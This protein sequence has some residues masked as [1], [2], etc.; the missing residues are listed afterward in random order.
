MRCLVRRWRSPFRPRL[1]CLHQSED[2]EGGDHGEP[3]DGNCDA[4]RRAARN[5]RRQY[6]V[7]VAEGC[8]GLG[9]IAK[10]EVGGRFGIDLSR[11][12][13]GVEGNE[14]VEGAV[15]ALFEQGA[16]L[17]AHCAFRSRRAACTR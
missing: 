1:D 11:L 8:G 13:L 7:Q 16:H 14:V 5:R 15:A 2:D 10:T 17:G 4:S 3:S 9:L 6:R 12:H